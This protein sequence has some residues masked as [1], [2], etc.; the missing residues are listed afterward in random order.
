MSNSDLYNEI[1]NSL[2][3]V[4]IIGEKVNLRRTGQGFTG[5]CPFHSEKTPSFHVWPETQSYYCFGCHE[6]GNIFTFIMKTEGLNYHE[7]LEFL[8]SRAG[9][10]IDSRKITKSRD[11]YDIMNLTAKFYANNLVSNQGITARAYMKRRNLSENDINNF[12]LG[13]SLNSWDSLVN[14][15]RNNNIPDKIIVDSGLALNGR[16]GIYD[17]F[18]GRLIFPVKDISGRIIAFGGRIVDGEGVKYINSP[19][20]E[21]YSKRKNLYLLDIARKSIREKGRAIL[22]EG[23]MDALRLHKCGFNESVASLGTSLTSEQ[24]ELLKRFADRCYICYDNDPAGINATIR[25]MYI[26]QEN[27]LDVRVINLEGDS[28]D[29][30]EFLSRN[31][32]ENF[33]QAV[34]NAKPLII[35]HVDS[36]R[37]ALNDPATRKSALKELF[38]GLARLELD[39]ILQYRGT[40]SEITFIP[41]RELEQKLI[42]LRNQGNQESSKQ[43]FSQITRKITPQIIRDSNNNILEAGLCWLLMHDMECRLNINPEEIF[44]IFSDETAQEIALAVLTSNPDELESLWLSLGDF[45]KTNFLSRGEEFCRQIDGEISEKWNKIYNNINRKL[46]VHRLNEIKAKLRQ[47][48]ATNGELQELSELQK[49]RDQYII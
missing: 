37:N 18:R 11:L 43:K 31:S 8:A 39:D 35:Y 14:Y 17:R 2:D 34:K 42:S 3:I 10:K 13:Y 29:P 46:T 6:G 27:G 26:L 30:D 19:E 4:D 22:V 28:K 24:A 25:G 23:Y 1:K 48:Q 32:P 12:S 21:I 47:G 16:T 15:L 20:S 41:P 40:I 33:E 38:D 36:L 9:I 7:A 45:E 5:L 49:M 44:K